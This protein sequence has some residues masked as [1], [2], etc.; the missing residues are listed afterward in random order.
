MNKAYTTVY[1]HTEIYDILASTS[2]HGIY[3]VCAFKDK[4]H[5]RLI[6]D[7]Q[8]LVGDHVFVPGKKFTS[9]GK[10]THTAAGFVYYLGDEIEYV[11][12]YEDNMLFVSPD[13]PMQ[14]DE[15]PL[16]YWSWKYP[17]GTKMFIAITAQSASRRMDL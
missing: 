7:G 17:V 1:P 13:G 16:C 8:V 3:H 10:T 11:G 6:D 14:F 15:Y 5:E 4:A 12:H 9:I 2:F